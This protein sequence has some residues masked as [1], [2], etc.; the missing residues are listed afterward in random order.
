MKASRAGLTAPAFAAH[1]AARAHVLESFMIKTLL[2]ADGSEHGEH[3]AAFLVRLAEAG[4]P[5]EVVLLNVQP[6]V[7]DWQ[8]HGL[9]QESMHAQ[10]EYLGREATESV[11]RLLDAAGL[12]YELHVEMGDPA[13]TIVRFAKEQRCDWIVMGTR[14][15]GALEAFAL[16]SVARKVIHL[17]EVPVT[18]MK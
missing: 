5:L 15:M 13:D 16:G 17:A 1:R 18:L 12:R 11:R 7:V 10:R 4:T 8:T 3:V 2:A 6:E 14:G 9:A